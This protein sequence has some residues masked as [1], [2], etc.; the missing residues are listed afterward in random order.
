MWPVELLSY[1]LCHPKK[2]I[3]SY[4]VIKWWGKMKILS[5]N[6]VPF[7]C[8]NYLSK[9]Y[10]IFSMIN[11]YIMFCNIVFSQTQRMLICAK[12]NAKRN[13]STILWRSTRTPSIKMPVRRKL[14]NIRSHLRI[15]NLKTNTTNISNTPNITR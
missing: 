9:L 12:S 3:S 8:I 10:Q 15:S 6:I 5:D 4:L 11:Q 13:A 1:I 14:L 7:H 2:I